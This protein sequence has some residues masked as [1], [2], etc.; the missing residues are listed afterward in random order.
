M[1]QGI[2]SGPLGTAEGSVVTSQA[3]CPGGPGT[4][5]GGGYMLTGG[6]AQK[7]NVVVDEALPADGSSPSRYVV[8]ATRVAPVPANQAGATVQA[9]AICIFR[10]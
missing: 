6:A 1:V 5:L 2:E 8:H 9:F 10:I 4:L 3:V 7:Q